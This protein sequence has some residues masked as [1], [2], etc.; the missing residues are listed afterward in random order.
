VA[1]IYVGIKKIY[2]FVFMNGLVMAIDMQE[3]GLLNHIIAAAV[4]WLI[5][6]H[7]R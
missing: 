7:L 1:L 4:T 6:Q 3:L 2:S 5:F